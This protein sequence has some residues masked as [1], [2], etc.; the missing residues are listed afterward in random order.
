MTTP[1][2]LACWPF[3]LAQED[4]DPTNWSSPRNY[5]NTPGDPG[6]PTMNGI[7]QTEYN[8]YRAKNG[9]HPQSVKLISI[10]EGEDIY[11]NSYWLPHC[12]V[13][14]AGLD[15]SFFDECVN[16]GAGEAVKILQVALNLSDDGVWG[17]KTMVAVQALQSSPEIIVAVRAFTTRRETVYR[18][19][20]GF[21][22]FGKDWER[23]ATEIGAEALKMVQV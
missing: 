13:L 12:P 22:E 16:A 17:P 1:R 8:F 18:E 5:S 14:P 4:P 11:F 19:L 21:A 7:I 23:R 20:R 10:S 2:F 9:L 6:G 15:L 3:T